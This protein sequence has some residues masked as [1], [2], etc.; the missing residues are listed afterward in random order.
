MAKMVKKDIRL[1]F[2]VNTKVTPNEYLVKFYAED[3]SIYTRST[4]GNSDMRIYA[5]AI[6]E[7]SIKNELVREDWQKALIKWATE[8]IPGTSY[9][10][11]FELY[12]EPNM[13]G[14]MS[15]YHYIGRNGDK[16]S[17]G[18][19]ALKKVFTSRAAAI[20]AAYHVYHHFLANQKERGEYKQLKVTLHKQY[21][22]HPSEEIL[23]L[24]EG[25]V[26]NGE[27]LK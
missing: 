15:L 20:K 24:Y 16:V 25:K 7:A 6:A 22:L 17:Y 11:S 19:R 12:S 3:G 23:T 13:R 2:G 9:Y 1:Q 18:G 5:D 21:L 8:N 10:I 27:L 14:N 4:D 26:I